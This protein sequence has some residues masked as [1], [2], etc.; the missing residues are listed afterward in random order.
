MTAVQNPVEAPPGPSLARRVRGGLAWS[1]VST[2]LLKVGGLAVGVVIARLLTPEEFGV[3]AVALT[4]QTVLVAVA[5]LGLSTDLIRSEDPE[6]RAP[7]VATVSA[8]VS[9]VLAVATAA[10]AIPLAGALGAPDAAT[11]IAVLAVTIL[12]AGVGVVPYAR[13]QREFDQRSLFVIG[14]ADFAVSTVV[15]IA[16]VLLGWGVLSL[17]VGRVAAQLVSTVLQFVRARVRPAFGLDRSLVRSV[18]RFGVPVAG[19]NILSWAVLGIDKLILG[20]LAGPTALGYYV[21]ASNVSSWPMSFLGQAV[22]GVALP[23]F[24][25]PEVLTD[26]R[27][28]AS[29]VGPV[30]AVAALGACLIGAGADPLVAVVYGH[31]WDAAAPVLVPLLALGGL[32]VVFDLFAAYLYAHGRSGSVLVVQVVWFTGLVAALIAGVSGLGLMGAAYAHLAISLLVVLPLYG[33]A[34][35]RAGASPASLVSALWCPAL[36][37]LVAGWCGHLAAGAVQHDV[38][39]LGAAMGVAAVVYAVLVGWWAVPRVRWFLA[40]GA[41]RG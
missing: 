34:V 38:A 24:S 26:R 25:R 28:P 10:T 9:L 14:L 17:A 12:L 6:R 11:A 22:R 36:G 8:V 37:A 27:A 35:V 40:T 15:T 13:L 7:T 31:A 18:I 20:R 5:D 29:V 2:V 21:L 41:G 39:A 32:R 19:A 33:V 4:V 1:A 30:W 23:L 16:L 3:Y